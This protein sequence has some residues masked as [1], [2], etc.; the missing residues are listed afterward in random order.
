VGRETGGLTVAKR[1]SKTR[2][3][4]ARAFREVYAKTPRTVKAKGKAARTKQKIAVALNKARKAG[5]RVPKK[6]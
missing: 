6:K 3:K 2:A 1:T 5:A 4:V